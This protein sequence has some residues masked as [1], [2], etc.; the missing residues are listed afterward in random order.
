MTNIYCEL[1]LL[2]NSSYEHTYI[3]TEFLLAMRFSVLTYCIALEV[4]TYTS[5]APGQKR[6]AVYGTFIAGFLT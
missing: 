5:H 1:K 3:S 2:N 6:G 4:G